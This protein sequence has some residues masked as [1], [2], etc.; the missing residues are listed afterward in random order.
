MPNEGNTITLS[1]LMNN[2]SVL[3]D[4]KARVV[5]T[6]VVSSNLEGQQCPQAN[7]LEDLHTTGLEPAAHARRRGTTGGGRPALPGK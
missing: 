5:D 4:G 6:E 3:T 2:G 7:I 1:Y